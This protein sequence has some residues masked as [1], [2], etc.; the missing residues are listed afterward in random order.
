MAG[1]RWVVQQK[2]FQALALGDHYARCLL[3]D[4]VLI[5]LFGVP[6][7]LCDIPTCRPLRTDT[8]ETRP[9]QARSLDSDDGI[10]PTERRNDCHFLGG[11]LGGK[12]R[13]PSRT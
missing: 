4:P 9:E 3:V 7:Q 5:L 8:H 12:L 2:K 6:T 10:A 1:P 13:R 11:K